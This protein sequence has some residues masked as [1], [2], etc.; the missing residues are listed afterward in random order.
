MN[1]AMVEAS[2]VAARAA[3]E[4]E[5]GSSILFSV[6]L[7]VLGVSSTKRLKCGWQGCGMQGI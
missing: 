4:T 3:W 6:G 5:L 1:V 2:M 7:P